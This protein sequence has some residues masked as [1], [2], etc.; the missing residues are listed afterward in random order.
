MIKDKKQI[1][2]ILIIKFYT[3]KIWIKVKHDLKLTLLL[4]N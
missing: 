3:R 1:L 2:T 4:I